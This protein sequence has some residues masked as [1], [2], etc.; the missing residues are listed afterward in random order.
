MFEN[1]RTETKRTREQPAQGMFEAQLPGNRDGRTEIGR[2]GALR[3]KKSLRTFSNY[4]YRRQV[5][6]VVQ[7]VVRGLDV[8]TLFHLKRR[9]IKKK[10]VSKNISPMEDL[11]F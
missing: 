10:P 3:V 2:R 8:E 9:V 1:I 7:Y 11:R 5:E 6:L 4:S